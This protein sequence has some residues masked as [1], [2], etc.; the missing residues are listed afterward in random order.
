M[1]EFELR[2]EHYR[3][4]CALACLACEEGNWQEMWEWHSRATVIFQAMRT[5]LE[6]NARAEEGK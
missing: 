2:K 6:T 1:T 5:E 3:K 4:C